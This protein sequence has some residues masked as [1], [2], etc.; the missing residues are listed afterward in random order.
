MHKRRLSEI[1]SFESVLCLFVV[2]IHVLSDSISAY[3]K[4]TVLSALSFF[5]S[6]VLTFVVPAFIISSAIKFAHSYS[7]Y[8]FRY[9][10]FLKRRITKI[11]I[12]YLIVAAIYYL[13]FVYHRHYFDFS[14]MA[15]FRYL[16]L[17]TIAAPFYFIIIIMQ[18]YI[19]AP[20]T[21]GFCKSISPFA[22]IPLA[23]IITVLSKFLMLDFQYSDRIFLGY[24]IYWIIG[25][26]IGIN[27]D[28]NLNR[29]KRLKGV[30]VALGLIFTA[31]YSAT[32]YFEFL[33]WFHSFWTE[34]LKILF[35]SFASVMWLLIMP[36][37]A[38]EGADIISP[39]TFYIYLIHCLVIF[40]TEHWLE[41]WQITA[42][43]LRFVIIFFS[44]YVISILAAVIYSRLKMLM[45][46]IF[47]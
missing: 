32:A 18:L 22:G 24:F 8:N 12:P 47:K 23:F 6:R 16:S 46:R 39:A 17:G 37:Y 43:P 35:A 4:G 9:F 44:A 27:F 38:H 34:I 5:T 36:E 40:E 20:I 11:Y 1:S 28:M 45:R 2:M 15:L 42:T 26:Y 7:D 41:Q 30:W 3:P 25:C 33:G 10:S 19:I 29:L 21:L 13:Y 14:W 31:L